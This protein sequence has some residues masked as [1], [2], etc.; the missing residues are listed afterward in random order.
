M[1]W[2]ATSGSVPY[3]ERRPGGLFIELPCD[4]AGVEL[5]KISSGGAQCI[6]CWQ[7]QWNGSMP[8]RRHR[9][10]S[11]DPERQNIEKNPSSSLLRSGRR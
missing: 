6:I 8:V 7:T 5:Q 2:R 1:I 9:S 11:R 10:Q 4:G 3:F